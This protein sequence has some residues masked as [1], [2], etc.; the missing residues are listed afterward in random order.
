[1]ATVLWVDED[2]ASPRA[3]V[4]ESFVDGVPM[5][6]AVMGLVYP[7][8]VSTCV[9]R[10]GLLGLMMSEMIAARSSPLWIGLHE[11][12]PSMDLNTPALYVPT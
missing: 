2:M 4:V 12:P 11:I 3:G 1:M 7:T 10:V 8:P 6:T 9:E 5:I